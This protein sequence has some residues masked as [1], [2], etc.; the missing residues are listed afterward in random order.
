MNEKK[1]LILD[2]VLEISVFDGWTNNTIIKACSELK[3]PREMA[4]ILYP[5]GIEELVEAFSQ[6]IDAEFEKHVSSFDG[7]GIRIR[8]QIKTL[9]SARFKLYEPYKDAISRLVKSSYF[10]K[11][12]SQGA[13]M[14]WSNASNIWYICG[15][16]STDHNYYSK[17]TL[18]SMV[19][20]S[21][22]LYW[23][24]DDSEGHMKTNEF[25]ERRID[26]VLSIGKISKKLNETF[27]KC[28]NIPFLRLITRKFKG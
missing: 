12:S 18:L 7:S 5:R 11:N 2:K 25:L 23:V 14:L 4:E 22:F 20:V 21:S 16:K 8:D 1:Q 19:Y 15:D 10:I 28:S 17:R 3:L 24:N 26:N 13:K 27:N 9:V 6:K